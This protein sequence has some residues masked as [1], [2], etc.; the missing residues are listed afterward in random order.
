MKIRQLLLLF[1][2][3]SLI[4]VA[5]GCRSLSDADKSDTAY[6]KKPFRAEIS[7][8]LSGVSF[9]AVIE[10][11][12]AGASVSYLRPDALSGITLCK[13]GEDVFLNHAG[14]Q[15]PVSDGALSGL[16]SPLEILITETEPLRIQKTK[17][18]YTLSLSDNGTLTLTPERLP[19]DYESPSLCFTV[20]WWENLA[21]NT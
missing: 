18:G 1:I 11:T 10:K 2:T 15:T 6:R 17:K 14:K 5:T 8:K 3:A 12:E 7:G 4:F 19:S 9:G 20:V 16:L 21:S 13:N